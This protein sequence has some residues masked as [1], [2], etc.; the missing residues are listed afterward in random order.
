MAV[1]SIQIVKRFTSIVNVLVSLH[2]TKNTYIEL[3]ITV[4]LKID[5]KTNRK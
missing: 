5:G 1:E 2:T 3:N 4:S